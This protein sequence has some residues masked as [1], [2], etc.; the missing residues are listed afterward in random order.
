MGLVSNFHSYFPENLE[1]E[2]S[3][4]NTAI[5]NVSILESEQLIEMSCDRNLMN[6]FKKENLCNF[7]I[8]WRGEYKD[9]AEKAV[10]FLMP[11][12]TSYLCETG[13]SSMLIIKNKYR[14][15]LQLEPDLRLKLMEN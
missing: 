13:F 15:Q 10:K 3:I 6:E 8:Q 7:W 9:I 4:S 1:N 14:T 2:S 5:Q 12:T 11:F